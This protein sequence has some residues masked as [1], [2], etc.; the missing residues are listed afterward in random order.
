M[1]PFA[2]LAVALLFAVL[3]AHADTIYTYAG[4][5]LTSGLLYTVHPDGTYVETDY[6]NVLFPA[7]VTVDFEHD[8]VE[9]VYADFPDVPFFGGGFYLNFPNSYDQY[10]N[11]L[12]VNFDEYGPLPP[13][14]VNLIG[15]DV[16]FY[17]DAITGNFLQGGHDFG[18]NL[19]LVTAATPEPCSFA[20]LGTG[21]LGAAGVLRKRFA[22]RTC[23]PR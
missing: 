7:V 1:R 5:V 15:S 11:I 23:Q 17:T 13:N 2:S 19:S 12:E 14:T 16:F 6:R 9:S 21:L 20:L 22:P 8:V 10:S 4:S 3:P 18:G